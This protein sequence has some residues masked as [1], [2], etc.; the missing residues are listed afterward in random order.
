MC[1]QFCSIRK[2]KK[3]EKPVQ[4]D[5][6][7]VKRLGVCIPCTVS[8]LSSSFPLFSIYKKTHILHVN[9]SDDSTM[10]LL[11]GLAQKKLAEFLWSLLYAWCMLAG[12]NKLAYIILQHFTY[13]FFQLEYGFLTT[14]GHSLYFFKFFQFGINWK[15]SY[16]SKDIERNIVLHKN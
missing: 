3:K 10:F 8:T 12:I 9:P 1:V 7:I 5:P 6:S 4:V 13:I 15:I 11:T 16:L 14:E 2:A